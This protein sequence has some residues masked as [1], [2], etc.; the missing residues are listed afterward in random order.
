M[1]NL[2]EH[3]YVPHKS[4]D[5]NLHQLI[6]ADILLLSIS[7]EF[8]VLK[9]NHGKVKLE[10]QS[11]VFIMFDEVALIVTPLIRSLLL[12]VSIIPY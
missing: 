4:V 2:F 6:L 1:I 3:I 7:I 11:T 12:I 5:H 9:Y 10:S 8:E